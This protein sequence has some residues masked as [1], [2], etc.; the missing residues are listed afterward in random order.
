MVTVYITVAAIMPNNCKQVKEKHK[1]FNGYQLKNAM[2]DLY[3][4]SNEKKNSISI[5]AKL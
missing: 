3:I 2:I 5:Y 4:E 1:M